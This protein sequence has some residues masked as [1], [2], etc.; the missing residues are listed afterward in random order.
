M[1]PL[2]IEPFTAALT[3]LAVRSGDSAAALINRIGGLTPAE[4]RAFITDA[5]PA[6][7]DPFLSASGELTAQWYAEQPAPD[8]K[9]GAALFVPSPAPLPDPDQ[10]AISARWALTQNDP[11]T[12]LRGNAIRSTMNVSRDTVIR[13]AGAEGVRWVRH[14]QPNA[15]GFCRMLA[16]RRGLKDSYRSE[17]AALGVVGRSV[18]LELSDRRMIAS[19]VM[20]REQALARRDEISQVYQRNTRFGQ[21]GQTRTRRLRGN[22]NY[23]QKYHDHCKCTAVPLRDG[24]Y[25]PP[26]Y[27][28]Q[29]E[30]DYQAARDKAKAAGAV[31][32]QGG[33]NFQAIAQIMDAPR[34]R[35]DRV[36]AKLAK[37]LPSQAADLARL[38]ELATSLPPPAS[39]P[40]APA[41]AVADVLN[42]PGDDIDRLTSD[43]LAALE[44]G[45][46][47]LADSLF[48]RAR[49]LELAAE[50][51]AERAAKAAQRRA[52]RREAADRD[53]QDRVG[54]LIDQGWRP[55]EAEAQVYGRSVESIRRRD[56]IARAR[57]DGHSGAGFDELLT[58]MHAQYAAEQYWRAESVLRSAGAIRP[59]YSGRYSPLDLWKVNDA[60]ARKIMTEEMA[61]WLDA[62]G[63]RVTRQVYRDSVLDGSNVF[64]VAMQ[65]DFLQ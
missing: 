49:Q 33:I 52:A 41:D 38:R 1:P 25:D 22:R 46:D 32:P 21:R 2:A 13:N 60:T 29:W 11:L 62:N 57:A 27:V 61:A 15:C 65:Q 24:S 58:Q 39:T 19:G 8:P 12:A 9:P 14:A 18:N 63:G 23:G 16:T 37:S 5:Y 6:L 3:E 34:I 44:A 47:T 35:T 51:K 36:T 10:L 54:A 26:D 48:E 28:D 53:K 40:P 55:D 45:D 50:A 17:A 64:D 4:G 7:L 30:K 56:F 31:G 43:A 59:Q 42:S 20:T